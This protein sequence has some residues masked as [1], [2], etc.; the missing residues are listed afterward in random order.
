MSLHITS[1]PLCS[2]LTASNGTAL[3]KIHNGLV[4]SVDRGHVGA[5]ALLDLS[6]AFD[7]VDHQL[8]LQILHQR[9]SVTDS[10]LC[11]LQSYLTDHAYVIAANGQSSTVVMSR[12]SA[13]SVLD[14]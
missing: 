4:T 8:L 1:S 13:R 12:R 2:R 9:F 14:Y 7:T 3:V 5:S 11:W 10:A 6:L